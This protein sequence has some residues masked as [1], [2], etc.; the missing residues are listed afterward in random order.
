M[1][2]LNDRFLEF[3]FLG[4]AHRLTIYFLQMIMCYFAELI[5]SNGA[6]YK[7]FLAA[8]RWLQG[9]KL[10]V[11]KPLCFSAVTQKDVDRELTKNAAGIQISNCN[12][13]YLG[14]PALIGRSRLSSFNG[15]KGRVWSRLNGWKE[16]FFSHAG[17]EVLL[18]AVIKAIPTYTMSV[19][20][21]PKSL[22]HN[23][24]ALMSSFWWG[25]KE[26]THK[27]GWM[28]WKG[29]GIRRDNGGLGF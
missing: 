17:K 5:L 22:V 6:R 2:R 26:N 27:I 9:R 1:Q 25:F 28:N 20:W 11:T 13:S 18:K 29:L 8:M 4:A 21:L 10:L 24:N 15:I 7:I 19:F 23:I 16:E 12:E 14:L 3:P